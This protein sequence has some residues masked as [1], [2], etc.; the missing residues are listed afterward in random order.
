MR[1]WRTWLICGLPQSAAIVRGEFSGWPAIAWLIAYLLFGAALVVFLG[2]GEPPSQ[3][4]LLRPAG[5]R[6]SADGHGAGSRDAARLWTGHA[7]TRP[8]ALLVV[9]AANFLT[10]LPHGSGRAPPPTHVTLPPV[11]IWSLLGTLVLTNSALLFV[12]D[13]PWAEALT[14][15]FTMGGSCCLRRPARFSCSSEAMAR[16][17]LAAVNAELLGTRAMLAENSRVEERLRI[18][19]DLHDTLG[20]HLTA[21]SLQLDVASRLSEG[22]TADH[23]RQAH[24][25]TRLLAGRRARRREPTA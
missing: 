7:R 24:A 21:L 17:Q 6:C 13:Y 1:R 2:L 20:H 14:F 8:P 3:A 18:S 11:W 15:G 4:W 5:A 23:I 19:R 12:V 9:I 22:K 16:Q 10:W 25:I